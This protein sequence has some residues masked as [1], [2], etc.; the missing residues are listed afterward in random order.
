M[1]QGIHKPKQLKVLHNKQFTDAMSLMNFIFSIMKKN[2][3]KIVQ[4][5]CSFILD[6]ICLLDNFYNSVKLK[7]LYAENES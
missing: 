3:N 1:T 4:I 5:L 7:K 2:D 6:K